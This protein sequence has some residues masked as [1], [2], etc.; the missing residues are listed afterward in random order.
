MMTT[1]SSIATISSINLANKVD[2]FV[3]QID[4]EVVSI[5][6]NQID[7]LMNKVSLYKIITLLVAIAGVIVNY[8]V[9]K[10][11][12]LPYKKNIELEISAHIQMAIGGIPNQQLLLFSLIVKN[13]GFRNIKI[14]Q[15]G[16]T[17]D[18]KIKM[19]IVEF[20]KK[21][22]PLEISA[23]DSY[24]FQIPMKDL[25]IGIKKNIVEKNINNKILFFYII[26]A[27]GDTYYIKMKEKVDSFIKRTEECCKNDNWSYD[28]YQK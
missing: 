24:T 22:F 3:Y 17:S 11:A 18:K 6:V 28:F 21:R 10:T 20:N 15:W 27:V 13:K 16:Y 8:F 23:N 1:F 2:K 9:V 26:D 7:I 4:D 25:L 19:Q 12:L 14:S 5:L